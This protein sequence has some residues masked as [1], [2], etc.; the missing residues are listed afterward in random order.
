MGDRRNMERRIRRAAERH[1]DA[2]GVLEGVLGHD[3][4]R[5]EIFLHHA[6][7]P[8][9]A[10][11]GDPALF[12]GDR[13]R[14]GASRQ[15]HAE[16]LGDAGHGVRRVHALARTGARA[17]AGLEFGKV[18]P[19]HLALPDLAHGLEGGD[20]VHAVAAIIAGMHGAGGHHDRR[21][22]RAAPRP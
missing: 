22:I 8:F 2:D 17:G 5:R 13:E 16:R 10:L 15:A 19:G 3:L 1:V 20:Q 4:A 21:D 9:A 18:A 11:E 7:D 12:A 6:D 14:G